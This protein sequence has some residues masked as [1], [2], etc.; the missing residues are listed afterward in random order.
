MDLM[1]MAAQM[2]G[3]RLGVEPGNTLKGLHGL[4][5]GSDGNFDIG[6]LIGSLQNGGLGEV[7]SSWLGDGQNMP[8]DT[9]SI[10]SSIGADKISEAASS[11]GV[12]PESLSSGLSEMIPN[13]IDQSSSGGSLLDS[14][15]GIGGMADMAKKF[16]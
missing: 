11:M 6:S 9:A 4:F 10:Q 8:V 14:I 1:N 2:L 15:G 7:V 3:E 12:S 5:D 13:L 16:F